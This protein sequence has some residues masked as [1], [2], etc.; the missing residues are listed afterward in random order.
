MRLPRKGDRIEVL[1]NSNGPY[2]GVTGRVIDILYPSLTAII[3]VDNEYRKKIKNLSYAVDRARI[4]QNNYRIISDYI[5][6]E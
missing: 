3:R 4:S 2:K 1:D 5:D 6:V